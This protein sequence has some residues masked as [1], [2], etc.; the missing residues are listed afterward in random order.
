MKYK[1]LITTVFFI[2]LNAV[3]VH[4]ESYYGADI[5]CALKAPPASGSVE[6]RDDFR[7]LFE[8]QKKRTQEDGKRAEIEVHLSLATLFGPPY[9]SL[10]LREIEI[11]RPIFDK[12]MFT[13][14]SAADKQ[15]KKWQRPRPFE[16]DP[17]IQP[18]VRRP[19]SRS[20]PSGHATI[21]A[22]AARMFGKIFPK[23]AREFNNRADQIAL[24]RVIAG[25]HHP[26]DIAAGK[27]CGAQV[28]DLLMKNSEFKKD[29]ETVK[30][31]LRIQNPS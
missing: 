15:K 20:Y 25:V 13:S 3:V 8:W 19:A 16:K 17:N 22:V 11:I 10:S 9:G 4:A 14:D 26:S 27:I 6:E 31:T 1:Y 29:L 18:I 23:R 2:M 30:R 21:V 28:F 24:D 5:E 12:V 7:V